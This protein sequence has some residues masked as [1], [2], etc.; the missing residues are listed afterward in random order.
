MLSDQDADEIARGRAKGVGG[1]LIGK[2]VDQLLADRKERVAQLRYLRQ[3]LKQAFAYLDGLLEGKKLPAVHCPSC[4]KP[5][6]R[7]SGLSPMGMV[8]F[9][10]DRRECRVEP[11]KERA[12]ER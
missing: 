8:Y 5:Y 4:G 9:H 7:A 1:P 3:R 12:N 6:V 2:W 10:A 11:M